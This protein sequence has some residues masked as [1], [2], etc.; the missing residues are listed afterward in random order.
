MNFGVMVFIDD[1]KDMLKGIIVEYLI[2]KNRVDVFNKVLEIFN[3]KLLKNVEVVDFEVGI[4]V[5]FVMRRV[6]GVVVVVYNVFIE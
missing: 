4:Y 5:I 3:L 2:G 1:E 6:Y